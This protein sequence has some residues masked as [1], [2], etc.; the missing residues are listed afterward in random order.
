MAPRLASLALATV[1]WFASAALEGARWNVPETYPT[2]TYPP[3][4][5]SWA[6]GQLQ[7]GADPGDLPSGGWVT[8]QASSG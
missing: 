7:T 2:E 6:Q 3:V 5:A 1:L 4:P 8:G